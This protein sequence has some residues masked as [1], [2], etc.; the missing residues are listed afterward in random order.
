MTRPSNATGFT[1]IELMLA[2]SFVALLLLAIA[3]V[4][5][6]IGHIY[7]KGI[8]LKQLNQAGRTLTDELQR[9]IAASRPFEV[10][11][12]P[13]SQFVNQNNLGGRLCLGSYSY[14]WNKGVALASQTGVQNTYDPA[15]VPAGSTAPI[16]LIKVSDSGAS[17]CADP[18]KKIVHSTATEL[19]DSGDRDL[20]VHDFVIAETARDAVTDQALYA[21]G[22]TLGTNDQAEL[23]SGGVSCKPPSESQ[24]GA[25]YCAVNRFDILARAGNKAEG[26]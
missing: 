12:G 15:T 26:N 18:N 4:T 24:G 9:T 2:M 23:I 3:M 25:D 6:Q 13:D 17:L 8:T 11:T 1:I 14:V 21:I 20:V 5:M 22:L 10:S 19:L 16:R 7:N